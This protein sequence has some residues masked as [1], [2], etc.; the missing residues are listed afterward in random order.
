MKARLFRDI[1]SELGLSKRQIAI[2]RVAGVRNASDFY[3]FLQATPEIAVRE[4]FDTPTLTNQLVQEQEVS[5]MLEKSA[6]LDMK[7]EFS[8]GASAPTT[9][10]HQAGFM[11]EDLTDAQVDALA[12]FDE[13][14]LA[15]E[16]PVSFKVCGDWPVRDQGQRGTCVS[17]ATTAIYELYRCADTNDWEDLSEQFLYWAIKHHNLDGRQH[18][19]GTWHRFAVQALQGYGICKEAD[20]PYVPTLATNISGGPPPT[21]ATAHALPLATKKPS[22]TSYGQTSGKAKLLLNK[23]RRHNGVAIALPVF[24]SPATSGHNWSTTTAVNYGEVMNPLPGW[25]VSG[26]H[27]VCCVGFVPDSE[28]RLGGHFIIRNSWGTRF[29]GAYLPDSDYVG[30]EPGYG[31]VSASYVDEFLWEDCAF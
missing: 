7:H 6:G 28:E 17:F 25:S 15:G 24:N 20:W 8:F 23:L 3:S 5:L 13:G 9:S 14:P 11:L 30:P 27:A 4:G 19:D 21:N 12:S 16:E 2:A 26:G 22:A 29:F 18:A 1:A 10:V 31:Q